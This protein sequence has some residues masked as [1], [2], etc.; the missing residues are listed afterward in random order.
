[1]AIKALSLSATVDYESN[2]DSDKGS[3][4]AT[5]WILGAIP[6]QAYAHIKDKGSNIKQSQTNPTDITVDFK[7]NDIAYDM[8]C[9][10]LK[11]FRNYK[12]E[13]GG[14]IVFKTQKVKYGNNLLDAVHPDI[15]NALPLDV[16]RE[17]CFEIRKL[18]ELSE[19]EAKN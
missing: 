10:G 15:M 3:P 2:F 14:D 12:D 16:I 9:L 1:M 19:V 7:A 4:E 11:G 17:L 8:V 5:V 13:P 6:Q 18:N